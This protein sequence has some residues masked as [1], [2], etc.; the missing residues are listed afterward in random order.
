MRGTRQ[1][2]PIV[3]LRDD[4][5]A[6]LMVRVR[7]GDT[8]AFNMLVE[9]FQTKIL[10]LAYRYTGD[11]VEAED[12]TQEIFLKLYEV[13]HTYIPTAKFSTW[14]YRIAVNTCLNI[15]RHRR[16]SPVLHNLQGLPLISSSEPA[17]EDCARRAELVSAV[18]R[19]ISSLPKNQRMAVILIKYEGLSYQEAAQAMQTTVSA[20][21]SLLVRARQ[22]LKDKLTPFLE[23][24]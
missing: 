12:I 6:E 1:G 10:N 13:R 2:K 15:L 4:P 16:H 17:P 24:A 23:G 18:R 19:A 11:S 8:V 5:D 3:P 14:L 20:I 9:R 7:S 21:K 22:G